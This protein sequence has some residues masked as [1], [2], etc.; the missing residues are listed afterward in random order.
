MT[1]WDAQYQMTNPAI[2]KQKVGI[3]EAS[4]QM[5]LQCSARVLMAKNTQQGRGE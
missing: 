1:D 3:L 4:Y 5:S 2:S